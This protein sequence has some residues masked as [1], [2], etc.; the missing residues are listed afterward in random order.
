MQLIRVKQ[1]RNAS[2]LYDLGHR[3][4]HSFHS[5]NEDKNKQTQAR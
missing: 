3:D 2:A 5:M 1:V 4:N